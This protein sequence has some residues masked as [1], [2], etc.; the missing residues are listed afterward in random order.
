MGTSELTVIHDAEI[1]TEVAPDMVPGLPAVPDHIRDENEQAQR[2][3]RRPNTER[4]FAQDWAEYRRYCTHKGIDPAVV[5]GDY[6]FNFAQWLGTVRRAAPETVGRRLTGVRAAW[7]RLGLEVPFGITHEARVW[8]RKFFEDL[9]ATG[10]QR[11]RGQA[12]AITVGQLRAISAAMNPSDPVDVRDR[13][14]LLVGFGIAGRVSEISGLDVRDFTPHENGMHVHV[15][16]SKTS[17]RRVPVLYASDPLLCPVRAWRAWRD[18]M[19]A[20]S[21]PATP[22]LVGIDRWGHV[23]IH[24]P[25]LAP[26]SVAARITQRGLPLGLD[27][28]GHSLRAGFATE[29][30]KAGHDRKTIA[31]QGG[32]SPTSRELERYFRDADEWTDNALIGVL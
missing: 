20:E 8:A 27:L 5:S 31:R 21:D 28:K 3:V 24:T 30:R 11:G 18:M 2:S 16:R 23:G 26:Q 22:M 7:V 17:P 12:P 13:A 4:A 14:L 29:A 19:H 9:T 1:V 15:R 6:L 25:R 32:W 10:E